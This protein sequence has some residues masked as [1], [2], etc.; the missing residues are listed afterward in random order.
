MPDAFLDAV[1]QR[2]IYI[3]QEAK[4]LRVQDMGNTFGEITLSMGVAI[5]PQHG[6][7]IE[8][9]LRAADSAL[10]RAKQEGRDRLVVV[11]PGW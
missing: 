7:T 9:I 11:E 1:Q 10:Y 3:L 4:N 2:A 5:Y 6:R 8:D